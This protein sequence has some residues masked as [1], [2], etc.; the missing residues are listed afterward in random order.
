MTVSSTGAS[1]GA[2]IQATRKA[3]GIRTTRELAELITGAT[4]TESIIENLESG[5]K[6]NLDV[7]QL[8]NIAMALRVPPTYLLAPI[9]NPDAPIDLPN[10]SDAFDGMT[11]IQFDAWLSGLHSVTYT[12]STMDEY[13]SRNELDV[14][15]EM[16][17]LTSEISRLKIAMGLE[18]AAHPSRESHPSVQ[19]FQERLDLAESQRLRLREYLDS[20]GWTLPKLPT[21]DREDRAESA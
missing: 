8:L 5:R 6:V 13:N 17:A 10:L 16:T 19:S 3:R 11:A 1:I 7:S 14:L 15:R 12:P 21:A 9:G 4:V 20:A 18:S 2:R